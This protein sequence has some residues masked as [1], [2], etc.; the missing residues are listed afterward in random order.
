MFSIFVLN[1]QKKEILFLDQQLSCKRSIFIIFIQNCVI[2]MG[3]RS[4]PNE[5][6]L[7]LLV[8]IP[9]GYSQ[10][11]HAS[12][13]TSCATGVSHC[14]RHSR[15]LIGPLSMK[16]VQPFPLKLLQFAPPPCKN[17]PAGHVAIAD[18]HRNAIE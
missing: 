2:S 10:M 1:F 8:K 11:A 3:I 14:T 6:N 18:G 9:N 16:Y 17:L 4:H 7:L 12:A 15:S 13:I 5:N